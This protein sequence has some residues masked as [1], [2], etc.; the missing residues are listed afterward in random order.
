M[1]KNGYH[2]VAF[3]AANPFLSKFYGYHRGFDIF[4]DFLDGDKESKQIEKKISSSN[5]KQKNKYILRVKP[6]LDKLPILKKIFKT[7]FG[8][9]GYYTDKEYKKYIKKIENNNLPFIRGEIINK[10]I[11]N[12]LADYNDKKPLFLWIHYMDIHQPHV[13]QEHILSELNLPKYDKKI[14]ARHWAEIST[15]YIRNKKQVEEL[16]DLYDAEIRYT[17]GCI[18]KLFKIFHK[19]GITK[20]N[21]FFIL[22]ADHGEEFGEHGGLGHEMKLYNEMLSVPLIFYGKKSKNFD[23][24][25]ASLVELKD[26]PA[27]ILNIASGKKITDISKEFVISQSL[28]KEKNQWTR[29]VSLQNKN[30]KLIYDEKDQ[31]NN[32]FYNLT[33][34]VYE[35]DNLINDSSFGEIIKEF[36]GIINEFLRTTSYSEKFKKRS[37][38]KI[39]EIQSQ[40][41]KK[42]S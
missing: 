4:K 14:I 23:K 16:I 10:S 34:D 35:R 12:W 26:I 9:K 13:P 6:F 41:N 19:N 22:T 15:H 37:L 33:N 31:L 18:E 21:S 39:R 2:T 30:Y 17:D 42:N 32:E 28:R 7:L 8:K 40:F 29:L 36:T 27:I 11:S 3:Q 24:H 5:E 25:S 38:Q 1:K 20:E